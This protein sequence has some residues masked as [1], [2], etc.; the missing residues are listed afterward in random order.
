MTAESPDL[1]WRPLAVSDGA[2]MADLLNAIDAEDH[3]WGQYTAQ[4]AAEEL[5]SPVDDLPTST[6]AVFDGAT[7]LG[8]SAVHYKPNAEIVHRVHA[9][10]AVR[11]THRR[12]G[13]GTKLMR[14]GLATARALHAL[15]HP[16]LRLVVESVYGEHVHGAVALYRAAGMTA[17]T[18]S[19]HMR[20]PLG[21]AVPDVPVPDGLRI[22]G[23]TAGTD[24]EFRAV[25]NEAVRDIPGRSQ[26]SAEEW[27][28]WAVNANFRPETS[29]LL[30]DVETGTAA[31]VVLVVSWE[32]DTVATGIR[33]AYFRVIAT[34]PA[35][36]GR[37][38]TEALISHTL[39]TARDQ[40]YGRA[41]LRVDADGSSKEF[42][43]YD[44]AGFVTHDTQVHYRIEL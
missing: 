30:R 28:V 35:Y 2:A 42:G 8:F 18:W 31:G 10:G 29:F 34:R 22:E 11:P 27:K 21:T 14:H 40:G 38:V 25:R 23:Y 7:M 4:D 15:H 16:T 37:G 26:L 36:E 12:R 3:V 19:R 9:A 39:K 17:T 41:S 33:D 32:A 24:E 6:L 43:V 1:I 13:L 20:H 5:D 44:K